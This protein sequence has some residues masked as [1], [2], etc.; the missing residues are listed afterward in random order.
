MFLKAQLRA[1]PKF[2]YKA[3]FIRRNKATYR[4]RSKLRNDGHWYQRIPTTNYPGC[5][6]VHFLYHVIRSSLCSGGSSV[7]SRRKSIR[8]NHA[9]FTTDVR[10]NENSSEKNTPGKQVKFSY[11]YMLSA[12]I[13]QCTNVACI[14]TRPG[15]T[16]EA[17]EQ[18]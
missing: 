15:C 2:K 18:F 5:R 7:D 6:L 12:F 16:I 8:I 17:A 1:F 9:F 11:G 14:I 10:V 13:L 3:I 4:T